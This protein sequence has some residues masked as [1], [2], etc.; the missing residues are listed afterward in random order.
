MYTLHLFLLIFK[1]PHFT[2]YCDSW[3]SKWRFNGSSLRIINCG[4]AEIWIGL[5]LQ[6]TS[7][8]MYCRFCKFDCQLFN[9]QSYW[10]APVVRRNE[11]ASSRDGERNEEADVREHS[12]SHCNRI[13]VQKQT[14]N[15]NTKDCNPR[16][17]LALQRI[18]FAHALLSV[19]RQKTKNCP[20]RVHHQHVLPKSYQFRHFTYRANTL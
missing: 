15:Y 1:F 12:S 17:P 16:I 7:L 14:K 18:L 4:K 13:I 10:P 11:A 19:N 5:F 6:N 20:M 9:F 8:K 3:K 2:T